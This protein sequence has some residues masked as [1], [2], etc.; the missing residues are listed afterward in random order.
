MMGPG[1]RR[2]ATNGRQPSMVPTSAPSAPPDG[3]PAP[4]GDSPLEWRVELDFG[5]LL[6][7]PSVLRGNGPWVASLEG[8]VLDPRRC[9]TVALTVEAEGGEEL[10]DRFWAN[11]RRE[12]LALRRTRVTDDRGRSVHLLTVAPGAV[13]PMAELLRDRLVL[14]V[15]ARAAGAEVT[16]LAT[17]RERGEVERALAAAGFRV[18]AA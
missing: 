13:E 5:H 14:P 11:L 2:T 7:L 8:F 16:L 6:K 17:P 1:N 15:P 18:V 9:L 12:E 10:V 3:T 4:S